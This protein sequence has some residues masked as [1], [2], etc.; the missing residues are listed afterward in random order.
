MTEPMQQESTMQTRNTILRKLL[1]VAGVVGLLAAA[2]VPAFA[3]PVRGPET[4]EIGLV[5]L[6]SAI[7]LN[8][9]QRALYETLR[10]DILDAQQA[11]VA[12]GVTQRAER[13]APGTA[14]NPAERLSE[15]I[16]RDA[17]RLEALQA[18]EPAYVAFFESLTDEQLATLT[19]RPERRPGFRNPGGQPHHER[20]QRP[21]AQP[22]GELAPERPGL[23]G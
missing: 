10:S 13:P 14:V 11:L 18:I 16:A 8:A 23:P 5:R 21:G 1:P 3:Q 4:L 6:A 15:R 22:G 9:D 2:S 7:E 12:T 17:A 19:E 20:F